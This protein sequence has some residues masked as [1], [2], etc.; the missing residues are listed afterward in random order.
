[1]NVTI[2]S[3]GK[4]HSLDLARELINKKINVKIY[5]SYPYFIAKKYGIKK[6]SYRSF[7]ILFLLSRFTN[8][9]F[10]FFFKKIFCFLISFFDLK[11]QTFFIVWSS[12]PNGF[13]KFLKTKYKNSKIILE[14]GSS[15]VKFQNS[16][17]KNAKSI[18]NKLK[19]NCLYAFGIPKSWCHLARCASENF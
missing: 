11:E 17:G 10:D 8:N 5:C 6:S 14:R 19:S 2:I 4:F 15:H 9:Q 18:Q 12:M 7:F 13:L 16:A 3:F 1:M